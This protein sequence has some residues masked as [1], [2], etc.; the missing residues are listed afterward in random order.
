MLKLPAIS[1]KMLESFT[2]LTQLLIPFYSAASAVSS[3]AK[4]R[5]CGGIQKQD[6]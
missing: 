5:K 4:E 3:I 6:S 2:T 1:E